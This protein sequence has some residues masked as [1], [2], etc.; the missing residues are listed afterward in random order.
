MLIGGYPLPYG[1]GSVVFV[2]GRCFSF[3]G[4]PGTPQGASLRLG[5]VAVGGSVDFLLRGRKPAV[6]PQ[7]K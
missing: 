6:K 4:Y 7:A 3:T 2:I 1:R 5:V